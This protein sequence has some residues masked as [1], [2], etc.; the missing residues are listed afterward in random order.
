MSL[1]IKK[2]K[3]KKLPG[4]CYFKGLQ[5]YLKYHSENPLEETEE[6]SNENEL[7]NVIDDSRRINATICDV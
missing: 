1:M 6:L 7:I 5:L 2:E 3:L 4:Y